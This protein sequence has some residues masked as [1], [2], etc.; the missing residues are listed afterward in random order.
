MGTLNVLARGLLICLMASMAGAGEST[1]K[2]TGIYSDMK[3]N[4]EGG[5]VLGT[6]IF[7]VFSK[8]GYCVVFQSAEG[9]P[10]VPVVVQAS[11]SEGKIFFEIPPG[12]D[13]RGRFSGEITKDELIGSFS[14][15]GHVVR[16]KRKTSYWQ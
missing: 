7:V 15:N 4:R 14:A 6:E 12:I 3:Y 5:D 13:P 16:L 1:I 9:E 10:N 11:I 2:V 8:Q